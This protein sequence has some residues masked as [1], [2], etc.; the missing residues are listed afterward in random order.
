MRTWGCIAAI[1]FLFTRMWI[2]PVFHMPVTMM[3]AAVEPSTHGWNLLKLWTQVSVSM[4]RLGILAMEMRKVTY[5]SRAGTS[6]FYFCLCLGLHWTSNNGVQLGVSTSPVL[7]VSYGIVPFGSSYP[8]IF[9]LSPHQ[10]NMMVWRLSLLATTVL[11]SLTLWGTFGCVYFA[12][13][14]WWKLDALVQS[15][16]ETNDVN[17]VTSLDLIS[18]SFFSLYCVFYSIALQL[19]ESHPYM[20]AGATLP[21][22]P[23]S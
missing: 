4:P 15:A 2:A 12:L 8:D 10:V 23:D 22:N 16:D 18:C 1:C 13:C 17:V 21:V 9:P 3:F 6:V 20:N 14:H 7:I 19:S 5:N 11:S